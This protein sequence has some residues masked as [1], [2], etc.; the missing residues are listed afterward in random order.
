MLPKISS[1]VRAS[2]S[3][4]TCNPKSLQI[5]ILASTWLEL[6]KKKN[7]W[8]SLKVP[9]ELLIGEAKVPGLLWL[10]ST[11]FKVSIHQVNNLKGS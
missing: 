3:I 5:V 8:S 2:F 7:F 4:C 11:T 6:T 10:T 1:I 9:K